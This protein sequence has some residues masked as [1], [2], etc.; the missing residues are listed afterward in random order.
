MGTIQ[1]YDESTRTLTILFEDFMYMIKD[2]P[3]VD[4]AEG[5]KIRLTVKRVQPKSKTIF[6]CKFVSYDQD[7]IIEERAKAAEQK[8]LEELERKRLAVL[9]EKKRKEEAARKKREQEKAQKEREIAQ[10]KR[11]SEI[12]AYKKRQAD[13]RSD[14]ISIESFDDA[15]FA[16]DPITDNRLITEVAMGP[17]DGP[18]PTGEYHYLVAHKVIKEKGVYIWWDAKS[19]TGFAFADIKKQ[20]G[21]IYTE[22]FVKVIGKH[23][24][25]IGITLFSGHEVKIPVLVNCYITTQIR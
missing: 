15:M 18:K 20:W 13:L 14:K 7:Y 6:L 24:A 5:Q 3:P 10:K 2:A 4:L 23:V 9:A 1:Q 12:A 19:K 21:E 11:Q 8:M 16:L 17:I 22:R 25:N